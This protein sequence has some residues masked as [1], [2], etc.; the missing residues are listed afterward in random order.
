MW[1]N[2][3]SSK[4]VL[5]CRKLTLTE[6]TDKQFISFDLIFQSFFFL[7]F[8]LSFSPIFTLSFIHSFIP[9]SLLFLF[10]LLSF[11]FFRSPFI[12]IFQYFFLYLLSFLSFFLLS[13]I[14][15]FFFSSFIYTQSHLTN[16]SFYSILV[17]L[18]FSLNLIPP[19]TSILLI[20]NIL[21]FVILFSFFF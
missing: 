5:L 11:F 10:S 20:L 7:S 17:F 12:S 6:C 18:S 4:L 16:Y 3:W 14:H 9:F 2:N 15:S 8:F 13:F 21:L 19:I 1:N